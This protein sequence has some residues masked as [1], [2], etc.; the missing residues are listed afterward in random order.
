MS[1]SAR[2]PG[3]PFSLDDEFLEGKVGVE[4]LAFSYAAKQLAS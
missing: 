1:H 3:W 4:I 2:F